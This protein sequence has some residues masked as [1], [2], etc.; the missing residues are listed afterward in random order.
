[1]AVES[2][3]SAFQPGDAVPR[4]GIY[5]VIHGKHRPPHENSFL[6]GEKFPACQTC[7]ADVKFELVRGEAKERSE[8]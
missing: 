1:M 2:G 8:Q 7:G 6:S 3:K 5:R 4:S